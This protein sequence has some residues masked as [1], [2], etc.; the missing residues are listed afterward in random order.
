MRADWLQVSPWLDCRPSDS[1]EQSRRS[2]LGS[3]P[4]TVPS[5]EVRLAAGVSTT[6]LQT[7]RLSGSQWKKLNEVKKMKEGTWTIEKPT[8]KTPSS[9]NIGLFDGDPTCRFCGSETE[10]A[11]H[12]ICRCEALACQRYKFFVKLFVEPK[13]KS[14]ALLKDLC[15]FV[16][17]TGLMNQC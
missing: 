13:D 4:F 7:K 9:Q 15:L 3:E 6:R 14:M 1:R 17:G 5:D 8:G 11:H 16:R 10:T 12:N 2:S